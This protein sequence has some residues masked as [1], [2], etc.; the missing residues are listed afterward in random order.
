MIVLAQSIFD[1]AVRCLWF[2]GKKL[3]AEEFPVEILR[4][5]D[6][7]S[8]LWKQ[9]RSGTRGNLDGA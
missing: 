7:V 3:R 4:H 5:A 2:D 1:D 6:D 8:V 9:E